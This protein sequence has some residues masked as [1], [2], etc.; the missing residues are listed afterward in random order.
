[1]IRRVA[2]SSHHPW[3][4]CCTPASEV[5][6]PCRA[7]N[8]AALGTASLLLP[9][10]S[11]TPSFCYTALACLLAKTALHPGERMGAWWEHSPPRYI[12]VCRCCDSWE[13]SPCPH[14]SGFGLRAEGSMEVCEG[15][16]GSGKG[17]RQGKLWNSPC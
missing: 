12:Q 7:W 6:R 8:G 5:T 4:S 15:S 14:C 2:T 10:S 11:S 16:M 17:Q 9:S 1:M 13:P 3:S